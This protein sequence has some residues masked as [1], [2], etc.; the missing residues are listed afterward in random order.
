MTTNTIDVKTE[1]GFGTSD[2]KT[3][4][5][6]FTTRIDDFD[7]KAAMMELLDGIQSGN[8]DLGAFSMDF[9][10]APEIEDFVPNPTSPGPG[11]V[12]P[13]NKPPAPTN[14]PLPASGFGSQEQPADTAAKVSSQKFDQLIP[15]KSAG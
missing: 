7:P 2:T 11:D 9:I 5:E 8:P 1:R 12:N 13:N 3:M 4:S 15:G 6:M 14:W 10:E